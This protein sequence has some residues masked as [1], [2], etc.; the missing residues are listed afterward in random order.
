MASVDV[1]ILKAN[2]GLMYTRKTIIGLHNGLTAVGLCV[3]VVHC[4]PLS[5]F[6]FLRALSST[7]PKARL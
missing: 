5:S 2:S 7:F 4:F 6:S 1:K 3:Y